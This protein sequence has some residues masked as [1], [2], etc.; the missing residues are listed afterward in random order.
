M[1]THLT[2]P[3]LN[4]RLLAM[5]GISLFLLAVGASLSTKAFAHTSG[6]HSRPKPDSNIRPLSLST[7]GYTQSGDHSRPK[8]DGDIKPLP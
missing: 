3:Q 4:T 1:S 6:D 2:K 7:N 8:P 5:I